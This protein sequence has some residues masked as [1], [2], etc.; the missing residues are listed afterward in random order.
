MTPWLNVSYDRLGQARSIAFPAS[1]ADSFVG[2]VEF[3]NSIGG[4][5]MTPLSD[6]GEN[7][8]K[9]AISLQRIGYGLIAGTAT[10]MH[11][12][13]NFLHFY[14]FWFNRGLSEEHFRALLLN[15]RGVL[16]EDALLAVGSVDRARPPIRL[17]VTR[18]LRANASAVIVA[19]NHPSGAAGCQR[20]E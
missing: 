8:L 9:S 2:L 3:L 13:Q 15:R 1:V 11:N 17:L 16:L 5:R 19:H 7:R 6:E 14:E 10:A 20:I 4:E 12:R 18:I